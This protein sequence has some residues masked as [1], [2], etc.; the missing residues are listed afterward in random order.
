MELSPEICDGM[1]GP[2][3]LTYITENGLPFNG[4]FSIGSDYMTCLYC[5]V[6]L[7]LF[8]RYHG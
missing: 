6:C 5:F 1:I 8:S 2:I 4:N 3:M 7:S